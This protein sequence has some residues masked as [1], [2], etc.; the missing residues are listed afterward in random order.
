MN[1]FAVGWN[2]SSQACDDWMN[3]AEC[4]WDLM[5]GRYWGDMFGG[6]C[7]KVQEGYMGE[8]FG[9]GEPETV[10]DKDIMKGKEGETAY[11]C[12]RNRLVS[13]K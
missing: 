12:H 1:S 6:C 11:G 7:R 9:V 3:S 8:L 10:E 5:P 13:V 2:Y 4:Q